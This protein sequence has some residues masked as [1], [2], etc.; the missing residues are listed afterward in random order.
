M[1]MLLNEHAEAHAASVIVRHSEERRAILCL[2]PM[3]SIH[4]LIQAICS[5]I[6]AGYL[7]VPGDN[8]SLTLR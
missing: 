1:L 3:N 6:L 2:L 7:V 4:L 5:A 8:A